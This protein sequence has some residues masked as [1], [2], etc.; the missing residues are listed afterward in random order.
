MKNIKR[1][2]TISLAVILFGIAII[3]VYSRSF[4]QR[5]LPLVHVALPS[6]A[7]L[8]WEYEIAGSIE[9]A[10]EIGIAAGFSWMLAVVLPYPAYREYI[11]DINTLS[12]DISL[13]RGPGHVFEG[14]LLHY[15]MLQNNDA[16]LYF[17][18]HNPL[19]EVF[20][21]DTASIRLFHQSFEI[22]HN[23]IPPPAIST[24]SLTGASYIYILQRHNS[25]WGREHS[26]TR[27]PISFAIPYRVGHL[28]NIAEPNLLASPFVL[29]AEA[30]I[31]DGAAV[32]IFD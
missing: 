17:G 12:A 18:Y 24:D 23:L 31:Y 13:D 32:R 16:R 11:S 14:A 10:N 3:Q 29:F 7:P 5:Q 6:S 26:I 1:I 4:A 27:K 25:F 9:P 21:Q 30:E 15:E 8:F 20:V 2:A 22:F 28:V 19:F